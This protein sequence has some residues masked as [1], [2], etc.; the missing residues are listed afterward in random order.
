MLWNILLL[1]ALS[2]HH[3][4]S[5]TF[6]VDHVQR[7]ADI[8]WPAQ[9]SQPVPV[10]FGFHGH[11]G[12][13]KNSARTFQI[14]ELW[15]EAVTVYMQGLPTKTNKVDPEGRQPGW[16]LYQGHYDDRDLKFFDEVYAFVQKKVHVD[17]HAVYALGHSN[18][19]RFTYLLLQQRAEIFAAFAPSGSPGFPRGMAKKPLFQIAGEK[20]PLV[21]FKG[22][23]LTVNYMK[24]LNDCASEGESIGKYATLYKGKDGNDVVAYFH[25]GGH[26]YPR[27]DAP[28][29]IVDF[30]KA[31]KKT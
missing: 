14:Q 19:G 12:N 22:Q 17:S 29:M 5:V 25:P 10:V 27:L 7:R 11:G 3:L 30:F 24:K 6:D 4:E 23:S 31:H 26:E 28:Q 20:D 2:P 1:A 9:T 13:S 15:P 21:D 8:Y 18:G 16:Q